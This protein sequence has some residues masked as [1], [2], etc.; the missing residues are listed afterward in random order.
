MEIH[1]LKTLVT[2]AREGSITRAAERLYLSQPAVS[3]HIKA[4]EETLGLTLFERTPKGMSLTNDGMRLLA[5]AE[6]TLLV[7]REFIEE[8]ASI[9]GRVSGK[10]H[11]GAGGNA[12][13]EIL[14]QLLMRLS[15]SYPELEVV[16]HQYATSLDILNGIRDAHLDAGFYSEVGEPDAILTTVEISRFG[17][18]LAA[19]LGLIP[20]EQPLDWAVLAELP[21]ICPT[22]STCCGR[23]AERLFQEHTIQ[24]K[25]IISIDSESV[26]R[27][28]IAGG[29]GVGLLH[30]NAAKDALSN[31]DVELLCEVQ[32]T[33]RV[34][35]AHLSSR[36]QDPLLNAVSSLLDEM[37]VL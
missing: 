27:T 36:N 33:V 30:A 1:Q 23:A 7:H 14:G 5:K 29:V 9:K 6:Q 4:I 28:L 34:L 13:T 15:E 17:I 18:F 2:V 8:A 24:P 26:T 32:S 19:P 37:S 11:I 16:V 3:A 25:Q 10:L 35:F 21:W 20:P 12:S 22:S 31:G